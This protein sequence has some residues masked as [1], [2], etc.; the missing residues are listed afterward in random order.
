MAAADEDKVG[1]LFNQ[2][3]FAGTGRASCLRRAAVVRHTMRALH[4]RSNGEAAAI[5]YQLS[6]FL[7]ARS[8]RR[9]TSWTP[10]KNEGKLMTDR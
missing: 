4:A 1:L 2:E 3:M 10:R 9:N 5:S 8:E 7:P 6:A